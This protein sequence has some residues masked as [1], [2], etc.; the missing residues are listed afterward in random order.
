MAAPLTKLLNIGLGLTKGVDYDVYI[1]RRGHGEDGYFGN[2]FSQFSRVVAIEKFK[3]YFA[4][5][6]ERD[7]EFRERVQALRGKRLGC[8]CAPLPCH[9][10]VIVDYLI[11]TQPSD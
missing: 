1:G 2:P 7:A 8:F 4:K 6:I 3:V 9:G 10:Q 5:R 11:Q